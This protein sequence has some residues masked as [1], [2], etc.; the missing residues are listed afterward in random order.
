MKKYLKVLKAN[1][2][3]FLEYRTD[4][5]IGLSS[6]VF[7]LIITIFLAKAFYENTDDIYGYTLSELATYTFITSSLRTFIET[8]IHWYLTNDIK[9]GKLSAILT[10]PIKYNLY[11]LFSELAWKINHIF[12]TVFAVAFIFLIY[13]SNFDIVIIT[14]RIPIFV[15]MTIVS[16]YLYRSFRK[17][18]G[19]LAFWMKDI[20]GLSQFVNEI[21]GLL[22]G[23]WVPL[24]FFKPIY[25]LLKFLPFSYIF[26]FPS[27][28]LID[29]T[30]EIQTIYQ[31]MLIQITWTLL[32]SL[33]SLFLWKK[34]L[35][36]YESVGI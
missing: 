23:S 12:F 19:N 17:I 30:I 29:D 3:K 32:F 18:L 10:K 35:K 21:T 31:I 2:I 27:R 28:I 7:N 14:G 24:D 15:V 4:L 9:S 34:G 1:F 36:K 6:L 26:Y 22:G 20:G 16:F 25:N 13:R 33:F 8:N 11:Q 5:V